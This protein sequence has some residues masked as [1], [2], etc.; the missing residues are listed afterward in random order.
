MGTSNRNTSDASAQGMRKSSIDG[1]FVRYEPL[2]TGF[3]PA[4]SPVVIVI[5]L[6]ILRSSP[7][8]RRSNRM[9]VPFFKQLVAALAIAAAGLAH[10]GELTVSAASSLTNAFKDIA[11][12]YETQYA[13]SKVLLNFGA[14]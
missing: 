1:V 9:K 12:S 6:C 7:S 4:F 5:Y 13:G 10:A 11:Q 3:G 2:S 8:H 14:S